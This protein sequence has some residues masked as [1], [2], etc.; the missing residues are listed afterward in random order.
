MKK[1]ILDVQGST[2]VYVEVEVEIGGDVLISG[3]DI[4]EAPLKVFKRDDYEYWTRINSENKDALL[5]ALFEYA[6]KG[7]TGYGGKLRK[8]LEDNEIEFEFSSY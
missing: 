2:S 5:L 4:G 7:D 8:L 6:F 3:Q 1:T